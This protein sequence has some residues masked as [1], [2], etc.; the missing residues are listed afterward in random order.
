[1]YLKRVILPTAEPI[2]LEAAMRHLRVDGF[3]ESPAHED[4]PLIT[5]LITAAREMAEAF[6]GRTLAA[7]TWEVRYDYLCDV[8]PLGR[9]PVTAVTGV[10]YVD[11]D[12]VVQTLD[13]TLYVVDTDNTPP[14]IRRAFGEIYPATRGEPGAVRITYQA[15]PT[16]GSSP[17]DYPLE[18]PIYQAML[19]LIG[20]LYENRETTI[21]GTIASDLP[22]G[23]E[24]LMRPY[25]TAIL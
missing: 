1:M 20:H 12:G 3:G 10:E 14:R 24:Y 25:R 22:M 16:D 17:N 5:G 4:E 19:L 2:T 23:A 7:S 13:P 18:R 21:V 8:L 6:T 9:P 15:G 11:T